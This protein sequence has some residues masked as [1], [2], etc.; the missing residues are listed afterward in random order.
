MRFKGRPPWSSCYSQTAIVGSLRPP[1]IHRYTMKSL[2]TAKRAGLDPSNTQKRFDWEA[3]I[4]ATGLAIAEP[5]DYN[6]RMAPST[7]YAPSCRVGF[8]P[9]AKDW[10]P[11]VRQRR[12]FLSNSGAY[13]L[14]DL[15]VYGDG[16]DGGRCGRVT[17]YLN[18]SNS[19]N[20]DHK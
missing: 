5:L 10:A 16:E 17:I 9:D 4:R 6:T 2:I 13:G 14:M 15:T 1:T 20:I 18:K 3:N 12:A 7:G 19:R 8:S 11:E